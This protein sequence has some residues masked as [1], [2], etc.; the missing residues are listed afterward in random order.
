MFNEITSHHTNFQNSKNITLSSHDFTIFLVVPLFVASKSI[1]KHAQNKISSVDTITVAK[2]DDVSLVH[3]FG[4][5]KTNG[6][7]CFLKIV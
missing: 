5:T 7:K 1:L 2:S 3:F 6:F 4:S